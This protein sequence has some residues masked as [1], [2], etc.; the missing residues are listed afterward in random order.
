VQTE[1]QPNRNVATNRAIVHSLPD[2]PLTRSES[3]AARRTKSSGP[4][5]SKAL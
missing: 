2:Q 1:G 5:K 4:E 3:P